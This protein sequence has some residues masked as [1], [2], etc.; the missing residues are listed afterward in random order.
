VS[1]KILG[2]TM[3]KATASSLNYEL[4]FHVVALPNVLPTWQLPLDTELLTPDNG[5]V[6]RFSRLS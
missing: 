1:R 2:R 6:S 4:F 3:G 5:S